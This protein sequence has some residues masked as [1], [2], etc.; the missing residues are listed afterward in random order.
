[1]KLGTPR[2]S[3]PFA[4]FLV[5]IWSKANTFDADG[6]WLVS[7][8]SAGICAWVHMVAVPNTVANK[9]K[10]IRFVILLSLEACVQDPYRMS[11]TRC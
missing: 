5:G 9:T 6:G 10:L 4:D 2:L 1:V 3:V 7:D 11:S 8:F